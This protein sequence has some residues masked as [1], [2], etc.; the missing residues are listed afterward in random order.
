VPAAS[1]YLEAGGSCSEVL[2]PSHQTT[3][4]HISEDCNLDHFCC[5]NLTVHVEYLEELAFAVEAFSNGYSLPASSC[6]GQ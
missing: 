5:K 2:V 1:I 4:C 3:K 6:V